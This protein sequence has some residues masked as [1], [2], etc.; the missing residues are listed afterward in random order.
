MTEVTFN[1][2][3]LLPYV[4]GLVEFGAALE[5]QDVH[6]LCIVKVSVL[7]EVLADL[8]AD[9][10]RS[11]WV[12]GWV[13]YIY[14]CVQRYPELSWCGFGR[15]LVGWMDGWLVTLGSKILGAMVVGV[16]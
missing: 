9:L 7:L 5:D 15:L 14:F 16:L 1:V 2:V 12:S 6:G 13:M 8:G 3:V 10:L 11:K 4:D